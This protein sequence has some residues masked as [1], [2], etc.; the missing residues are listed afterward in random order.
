MPGEVRLRGGSVPVMDRGGDAPSPGSLFLRVYHVRCSGGQH[1][2]TWL[3]K[4]KRSEN[5]G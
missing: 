4:D 2:E 1:V 5:R 3:C